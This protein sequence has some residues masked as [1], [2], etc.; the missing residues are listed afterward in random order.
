MRHERGFMLRLP[1]LD[2]ALQATLRQEE[3]LFAATRVP[4]VEGCG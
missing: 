4:G 3:R 1:E 2:K